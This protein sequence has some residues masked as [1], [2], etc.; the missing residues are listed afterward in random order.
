[1]EAILPSRMGI[2]RVVTVTSGQRFGVVE[3]GDPTG[4]PILALHGAPASRL[5][6]EVA[7]APARE[8]GLRLIAFDRPGYGL[9]PRDYG[10]TLPSRTAIFAE[11]PDAMHIE[12][13]AMIGVSGGGPYA[14]AL[15]AA[16]RDRVTALGLISPLGPV[17]DV[18][19][20][21]SP[22]PVRLSMAHRAFF[23]DL[24]RHP[25]VLRAN[26]EIAMRSF[27]A[28]PRFFSNAFVHALP[29]SDRATLAREEVVT[30]IIDM[31]LEATNN[32]IGGGIADLEIYAEPW[33]V[34]YAAI[35]APTRLWQ[36]TE[37]TIVPSEATF[38]LA[39]MIPGCELKRVHG[40]GH[41]WI[42]DRISKTLDAVKKLALAQV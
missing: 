15:A 3:Y 13:F 27:R 21:S 4:Y 26:A 19:S 37:D 39:N 12:R 7:D 16:L 31:T 1:M 6:F 38:R 10:A 25:W 22:D 29:V 28:A 32:G 23:L 17:A 18:A 5:M 41:F 20:R 11:I 24:P 30:S 9:S 35:T 8:L 33:H 14:V 36:G 40:G 42:Y 34:D 2:S